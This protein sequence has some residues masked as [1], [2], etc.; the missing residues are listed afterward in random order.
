MA[1]SCN[2]EREVVLACLHESPCIA[3]GRSVK[4]CLEVDPECKE[5]RIA[6]M[7]C[8]RGQLDMRK[9]IKGNFVGNE[10]AEADRVQGS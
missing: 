3:E 2:V 8:K 1:S 10:T 9:R 7:N 4:E 5:K 6:L